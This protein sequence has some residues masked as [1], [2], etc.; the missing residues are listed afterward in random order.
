M[1]RKPKL[2]VS[3]R[4][5]D[6]V[7]ARVERD[8]DAAIKAAEINSDADKLV[9]ASVGMDG[10]FSRFTD[11]WNAETLGRLADSVGIIATYAVATRTSMWWRRRRGASSSPTRRTY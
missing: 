6:A 2:L 11:P 3:C 8:Y 4:P 7:L 10:I 9:A 5:T 1:S